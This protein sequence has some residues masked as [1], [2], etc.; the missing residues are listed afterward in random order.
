MSPLD[1]KRVWLE[2]TPV[3]IPPLRL[4]WTSSPLDTNWVRLC[5]TQFD[6]PLACARRKRLWPPRPQVKVSS[7]GAC[8]GTDFIFIFFPPVAETLRGHGFVALR[9]VLPPRVRRKR[10]TMYGVNLHQ[11]L[12][13]SVDM[14]GALCPHMGFALSAFSTLFGA[15]KRVRPPCRR[16]P[17]GDMPPRRAPLTCGGPPPACAFSCACTDTTCRHDST[18][19]VF[20]TP[21]LYLAG[22]G[23][24]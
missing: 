11:R 2:A 13:R 6:T 24:A 14:E 23:G 7:P 5:R 3:L 15:S 21:F 17:G 18:S 1:T 20:L 22:C 4:G 8:P 19:R 12:H 16:A 9:G 10:L